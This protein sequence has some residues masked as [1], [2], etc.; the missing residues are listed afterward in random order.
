[1]VLLNRVESLASDALDE[2]KAA[3]QK[4][5]ATGT[6]GK[7]LEG[8][9]RVSMDRADLDEIRANVEQIRVLLQTYIGK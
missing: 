5:Q 7:G 9:G 3:A 4:A 6:V 2:K 8:S 1:L